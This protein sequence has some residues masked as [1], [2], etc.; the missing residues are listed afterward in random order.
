MRSLGLMLTASEGLPDIEDEDRF[1]HL[2]CI[3]RSGSGKST[4]LLNLISQEFDNCCIIIDPAGSFAE[5][6]ASLSPPD[7]LIYIDKKHPIIINPLNRPGLDWS[8]VANEFSEVMNACVSATTSSPE[9]SVLM[10]ELIRN[11]IRV[12]EGNDKSIKHM[13]N[14]LNTEKTREQYKSDHYWG[15][16]DRAEKIT[17]QYEFREKR[18]SAK[19]VGSRLSAFYDNEI[20]ESF[21]IG[22]NEFDVDRFVAN[23]NIV[24]LNLSGFD[25]D[26]KM[27]LGNLAVSAVKSYYNHKPSTGLDPLYLYVDEFHRFQIPFWEEMLSQARKY[28]ISINIAHQDHEQIKKPVLS[29]ILGNV[30]TKVVFSCGHTEAFTMGNEFDFKPD[31]LKNLGKYQA[32]IRIGT[33]NH[34]VMTD[35]PPKTTPFSP[36]PPRPGEKIHN[37]LSTD[38][39]DQSKL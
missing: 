34:K 37:F 35:P 33:K 38:W 11:S 28:N 14:I 31:V 4:F 25:N 23:K 15:I 19:R 26:T 6:V 30:H 29:S 22:L 24:V 39:I 3:G 17:R 27:Y 20:M 16:F 18:D 1:K 7:R 2:Y 12:L 13:A 32:Y 21:T 36:P 8:E 10:N 9:S 5:S